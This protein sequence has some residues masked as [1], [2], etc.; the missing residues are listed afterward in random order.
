[1]EIWSKMLTNIELTRA[2]WLQTI[3]QGNICH[4]AQYPVNKWTMRKL[5]ESL[6]KCEYK[7]LHGVCGMPMPVVPSLFNKAL[8][9]IR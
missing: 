2:E 1:M 6:I 7:I 3:A 9:E 4:R 5:D 8:H